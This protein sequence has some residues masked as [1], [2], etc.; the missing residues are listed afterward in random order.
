MLAMHKELLL[1]LSDIRYIS[2]GCPSCATRV[3]LDLG[4]APAVDRNTGD[5]ILPRACPNCR[6]PFDSA[7]ISAVRTLR[8][9]FA[10]FAKTDTQKVTFP[11]KLEDAPKLS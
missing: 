7:L 1:S 8:E 9:A 10:D 6:S 11:I 3:V 4:E 2:I 5:P